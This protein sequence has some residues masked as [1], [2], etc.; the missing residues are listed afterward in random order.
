[1]QNKIVF[2]VPAYN[3]EKTI[4]EV[5]FR[6]FYEFPGSDIV[7][8]DDGSVDGTFNKIKE[9]E[10]YLSVYLIRFRKN[11]GKSKALRY[12]FRYILAVSWIPYL[13]HRSYEVIITIDADMQHIPEEAQSLINSVIKNKADIVVG[14]RFKNKKLNSPFYKKFGNRILSYLIG[15]MIPYD[16][17]DTQCGFRAIK[18]DSLKKM[19]LNS[20]KYEIET[21]M[22]LEASL[23]GLKVVEVP[24]SSDKYVQGIGIFTG[25][26]L[27]FYILRRGIANYF[28]RRNE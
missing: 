7:V 24:I 3:E 15:L 5:L 14:T 1:M 11:M 16:L 10:K 19:R 9:V 6:I 27:F 21:E 25:V 22:L 8:V 4:Q 17:S 13:Y 2:L 18:I 12:G 28:W 20:S 26:K 23:R